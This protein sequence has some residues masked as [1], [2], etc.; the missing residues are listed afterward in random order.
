MERPKATFEMIMRKPPSHQEAGHTP[1]QATVA[2]PPT[3]VERKRMC[4]R[5][6]AWSVR[7]PKE[8]NTT[9]CTATEIEMNSDA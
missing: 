5:Q 3:T 6:P 9:T 2:T 7:A 1:M 8:M 4:L